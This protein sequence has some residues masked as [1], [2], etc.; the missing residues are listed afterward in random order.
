LQVGA[1]P[2]RESEAVADGLEA[3]GFELVRREMG[4]GVVAM[5]FRRRADG[6]SAVRIVTSQG[7]AFALQAPRVRPPPADKVALSRRGGAPRDLDGDGRPEL[8]VAIGQ[9]GRT[10]HALLRV[11][12]NGRVREVGLALDFAAECIHAVRDVGAGPEPEAIAQVT[13]R[14]PWPGLAVSLRVPLRGREGHWRPAADTGLPSF[15]QAQRAM[16]RATL[17][18]ARRALDVPAAYR[19]AVELSALARVAGQAVAAQVE[20]FDDALRGLVL[21]EGEAVRVRETR[22]WI[23]SGWAS[24]PELRPSAA[25]ARDAPRR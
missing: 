3:H 12:P 20:A 5:G 24:D 9:G 13:L 17:A 1:Q 15:Y 25:D 14:P 2:E 6:A 18:D 21:S 8:F 10:C 16:R 19:A 4:P 23:R 7:I 11:L 22:R